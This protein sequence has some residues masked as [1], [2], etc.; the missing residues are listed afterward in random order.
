MTN[1]KIAAAARRAGLAGLMGA[2]LNTALSKSLQMLF[3]VSVTLG[4]LAGSGLV[5]WLLSV[6]ATSRYGIY[7]GV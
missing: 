7:F 2:D 3:V 5:L 4:T 6:L 1:I